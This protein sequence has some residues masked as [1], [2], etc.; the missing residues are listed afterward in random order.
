MTALSLA[1]RPTLARAPMTPLKSK[2]AACAPEKAAEAL[3]A[4][5][6]TARAHVASSRWR[7]VMAMESGGRGRQCSAIA[8]L[9]H[10]ELQRQS[11]DEGQ[12]AFVLD[13]VP[14]LP[15]S[16]IRCQ[17]A[18][19]PIHITSVLHAYLRGAQKAPLSGR[20]CARSG[21]GGHCLPGL[22]SHA[23]LPLRARGMTRR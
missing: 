2:S 12:G 3:L 8:D 17:A 20:E 16:S 5:L 11:A 6:I 14:Q 1:A 13:V 21:R 15:C 10:E 23:L 19:L 18:Q 4:R 22:P 7:G 9:Q